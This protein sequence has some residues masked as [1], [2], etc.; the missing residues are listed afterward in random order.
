MSRGALR[1]SA[2]RAPTMLEGRCDRSARP[3]SAAGAALAAAAGRG[4]RPVVIPALH[5]AECGVAAVRLGRDPGVA[6]HR[7]AGTFE[8]CHWAY[9][10]GFWSGVARILRGRSFFT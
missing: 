4:W 6:P 2:R 10:F 9:G 1:S 7:V 8:V 3:T 5:A